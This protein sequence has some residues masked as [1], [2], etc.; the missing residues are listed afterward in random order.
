MPT[1]RLRPRHRPDIT[2]PGRRTP[3]PPHGADR[4]AR[5][6]PAGGGLKAAQPPPPAPTPKNGREMALPAIP[7]EILAD[8]FLH[9]PTPEDL[10]RASA[11]CVSFHRLV[12][13]RAF[14]RRFRKLHPAPLLG[15][16][17]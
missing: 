6:S 12:A 16:L 15:F 11:A 2:R 8:I 1:Q 14:L 5:S 4:S 10:I 9:L 13:D 3:A 7:N 17:D